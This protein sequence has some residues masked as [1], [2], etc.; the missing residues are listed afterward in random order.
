MA[1]TA[2]LSGSS[3]VLTMA[4]FEVVTVPACEWVCVPDISQ[5]GFD[6]SIPIVLSFFTS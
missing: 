6:D 2:R 4:F 1:A 5:I 3:P